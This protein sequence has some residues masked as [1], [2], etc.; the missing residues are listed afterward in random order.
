MAEVM[1][2]KGYLNPSNAEFKEAQVK[3]VL[4]QNT[5]LTGQADWTWKKNS[6]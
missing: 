6:T 3:V 1:V 2:F 4:T 5:A